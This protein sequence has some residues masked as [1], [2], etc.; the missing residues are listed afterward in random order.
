MSSL[1]Y[2]TLLEVEKPL[3]A[4]AWSR[5]IASSNF[6]NFF[7]RPSVHNTFGILFCER[8]WDLTKRRDDIV[9][10]DMVAN[11]V[12]DMVADNDVDM[13][14]NMEVDVIADMMATIFLAELF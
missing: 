1:P 12:A 2:P 7:H 9:V 8:P 13:V 11:I 14:A 4:G 10:A 3:L 5:A 6:K